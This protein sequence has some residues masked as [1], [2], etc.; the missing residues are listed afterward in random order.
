MVDTG[1]GDVIEDTKEICLGQYERRNVF[2]TSGI[3]KVGRSIDRSWIDS[4]LFHASMETMQIIGFKF[5]ADLS[6]C[7]VYVLFKCY[8]KIHD[9]T[10]FSIGTCTED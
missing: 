8:Y 1:V 7:V 6:V 5:R 10:C 9:E 4:Y 3:C 2:C